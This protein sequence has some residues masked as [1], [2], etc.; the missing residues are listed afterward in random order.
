MLSTL[1]IRRNIKCQKL[2]MEP[3]KSGNEP[4]TVL[5]TK[6]IANPVHMSLLQ[7]TLQ[8]VNRFKKLRKK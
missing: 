1:S 2:V 7:M 6:D 4:T 3:G 5:T 8:T